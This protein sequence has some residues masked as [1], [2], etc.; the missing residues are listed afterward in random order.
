MDSPICQHQEPRG[1]RDIIA[2]GLIR[3]MLLCTNLFFKE[4]YGHRVVVLETI[5]AI[6]G[7]VGGTFQHL[8]ALRKIRDDAGWIKTLVDEA[9][10]ERMHLMV[11]ALIAKPTK[12]E[13]FFIA[14][15]QVIFY[16]SYFLMYLF[17]AYTAHRFVGYLEEEAVRSY[18]HYLEHIE[19]HP[20]ENIPAP[21]MAIAYWKLPADAK[22]REVVLATR[23]DEIRHRDINHRFAKE[24]D[25]VTK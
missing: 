18:T 15:A 14:V 22:L 21:E 9:E 11:F 5:A 4:R 10:N 25:A 2:Y 19:K 23:E 13:R 17:S 6:P 7:I 1:V 8:K 3:G 24:C 12:L 16:N 20:E